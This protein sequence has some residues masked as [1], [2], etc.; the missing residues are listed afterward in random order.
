MA[1]PFLY[2]TDRDIAEDK[3]PIHA[4]LAT[5]A[6]HHA[7]IKA[8]LR[9]DT[10]LIIE[11]GTTRDS[12]H[13][14]VL[15][16]YGATAIFPYLAYESINGLME[17]GEIGQQDKFKLAKNYRKGINKGLFKILSKMGISTSR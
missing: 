16:G 10:N 13:F 15:L 1:Q 14:A 7:L 6:V 2:L 17:R 9:C 3:L 12:H 8:G 4:A 11:T 5:G